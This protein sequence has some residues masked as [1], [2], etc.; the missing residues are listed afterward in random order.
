MYK[1]KLNQSKHL[2]LTGAGVG[3][4]LLSPLHSWITTKDENLT[5]IAV[6]CSTSRGRASSQQP[7]SLNILQLQAAERAQL[8]TAL[9]AAA[10]STLCN[11]NTGRYTLSGLATIH[12]VHTL[13]WFQITILLELKLLKPTQRR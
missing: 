9:F 8:L 12:H 13:R 5:P 10:R 1:N 11:A 2:S 6:T 7:E 3:P 4:G